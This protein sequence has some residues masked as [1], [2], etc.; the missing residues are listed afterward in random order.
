MDRSAT[1]RR[2]AALAGVKA[3][4]PGCG[5]MFVPV[6]ATQRHCRPSCR[7]AAF[8]QRRQPTVDLFTACADAIEPDVVRFDR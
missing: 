6:R 3:R 7:V 2:V 4:C 5:V 8:E 1:D